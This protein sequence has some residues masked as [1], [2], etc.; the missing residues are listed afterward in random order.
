[1]ELGAIAKLIIILLVSFSP[2]TEVRGGIPLAVGWFTNNITML[3]M[4][5][6][7]AV[8]G[9]LMIAPFVLY[10]LKYIDMFVRNSKKM[11]K[12]VKSLY[13]KIL[14]YVQKRGRKFE[15]YEIPAL[16][17]FVA[18]PL[19]ATGAWTASLIAFL[20]GM[21]KKKALIAIEL[22]V[23]GA[24]AIVFTATYAGFIILK[25]IFGL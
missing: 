10:L 6:F 24:S 1:L 2:I 5:V 3:G 11:P 9:N 18:I 15:K 7:I 22:G 14:D 16:A 13:I 25:R 17:I 12:H 4:G 19:P 23:L 21:N 20:L 8:L